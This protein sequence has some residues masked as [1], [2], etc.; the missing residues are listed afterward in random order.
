MSRLDP[1]SKLGELLRNHH[2]RYLCRG[3]FALKNP[4]SASRLQ[5]MSQHSCHVMTCYD[6]TM[7]CARQVSACQALRKST[8]LP[9]QLVL[10]L[11]ANE[12]SQR[13]D[14][15]NRQSG[16]GQVKVQA[17]IDVFAL[18]FDGVMVDSEP[19]VSTLA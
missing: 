6:K 2:E 5:L 19:E 1:K 16:K 11:R 8:F 18:D 9:Q 12:R 3:D 4:D 13:P 10:H 17:S 15:R 14:R 7:A